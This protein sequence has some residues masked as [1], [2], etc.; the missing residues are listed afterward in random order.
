[1]RSDVLPTTRSCHG[2]SENSGAVVNAASGRRTRVA[3]VIPADQVGSHI[4]G[5]ISQSV[6]RLTPSTSSMTHVPR[7]VAQS[8]RQAA[9]T[10]GARH[11]AAGERWCRRRGQDRLASGL[12]R[13][14][15]DHGEDRR[16]RPD[17]PTP[18]AGVR[19]AHHGR[20][21]RL[22]EGQ[23]LLL[24]RTF[25]GCRGSGCLATR[26]SHSC[27]RLRRAIGTSSTQPT[28]IRRSVRRPSG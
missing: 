16:R 25:A 24:P 6:P 21:S 18:A 10:Q 27:R 11:Q 12:G 9:T 20:P 3:V 5:V 22:H 19:R 13:R 26:C 1:M 4:L 8:S 28:G 15:P 14:L 23:S 2:C 17:G 7:R